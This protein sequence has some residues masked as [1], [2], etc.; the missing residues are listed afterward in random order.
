MKLLDDILDEGFEAF[1]ARLAKHRG[2]PADFIKD[3][4]DIKYS[5]YWR[6]RDRQVGP[7]ARTKTLKHLEDRLNALI[8]AEGE[9][10]D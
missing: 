5:T 7:S 3:H 9:C 6:A 8:E 10:Y 1:H 4:C 2:T